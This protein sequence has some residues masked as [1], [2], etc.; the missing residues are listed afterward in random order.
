MQNVFPESNCSSKNKGNYKILVAYASEFG[1][2]GEVAE[3]IGEILCQEGNTVESKWI[4]N[5]KN[6]NNYDA[7]IIGSAIQYNR[8]MPEATEFVTANQNIL[9]KLPVAYFFTCLAL[10][11]QA[12]KGEKQAMAYSDKLYSLVPQVKPLSVGRFAGVLDYSK[13]FF[14]SRLIFK[15]ILS[16]LGV[17]EGDYRDWEAIRL[18]A[19]S[20]HFKLADER[21]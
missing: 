15:V 3:V 9:S 5:V 19:K 1:T 10:S 16:I 20:M 8:W 13:M 2:T 14:F 21:L 7:V 4:N 6:L 18:W 17:Q 11:L 12:G